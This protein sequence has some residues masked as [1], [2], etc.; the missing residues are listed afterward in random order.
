VTYTLWHC[1][2]QIGE[3][4]FE[5]ARDRQKIGVFRP[6][7]YG[8]ELLPRLSG[9]LSAASR[10]K[11]EM[12]ARGMDEH[13]DPDAVA[14]VLDSTEGGRAMIE[15]GKVLSEVELRDPTGKRLEFKS[16]A[17][18]D[19]VELRRLCL[20]LS[21]PTPLPDDDEIPPNGPR[22]IVSVTLGRSPV[23][24]PRFGMTSRDN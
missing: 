11:A 14:S 20:E 6:T 24:F 22:Y 9:V 8:L 23:P 16:I 13:S 2:V 17:F 10:L 12:A 3:T 7:T 15:L 4:R 1:G 5:Q 18:S 21:S 19:L